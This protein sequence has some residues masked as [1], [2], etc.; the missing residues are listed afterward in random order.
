MASSRRVNVATVRL[1]SRNV[2]AVAWNADRGI[3]TFE[4]EP[5]FIRQGLE[6]APLTMPL[7]SGVLLFS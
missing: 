7:R 1:W 3:G 6:V 4:Y 5:A 2:G